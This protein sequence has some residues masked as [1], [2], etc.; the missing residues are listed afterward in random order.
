MRSEALHIWRGVVTVHKCSVNMLMVYAA[1]P[2]NSKSILGSIVVHDMIADGVSV[3]ST[4]CLPVESGTIF[5]T[6]GGAVS[7]LLGD[8][9][10]QK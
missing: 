5:L 10:P 7:M 4:S 9:Q 2:W 3:H 6:A 1:S 8:T